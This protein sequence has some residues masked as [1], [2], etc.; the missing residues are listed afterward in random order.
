MN[1][2]RRIMPSEEEEGQ[3]LVAYL[4]LKGYKFHHSPNAT[5]SSREA[6]RRA[7]RMKRAG[8]SKGFPDYLV[9][10]KKGKM[11]AIELKRLKGSKTSPEQKEWIDYFNSIGT[12]AAIC[13]GWVEAK[14]FIEQNA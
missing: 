13:K 4:R 3:F 6:R 2:A 7:V 9:W 5:G 14:E 11:L 12:P 10:T 8:T 1:T